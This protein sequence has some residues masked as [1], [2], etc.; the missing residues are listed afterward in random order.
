MKALS[1][2]AALL[3]AFGLALDS[4]SVRA[5]Q[6]SDEEVSQAYIYL[7]G[8]LLVTRQQQLDFQD[9]FKWNEIVHRKP[10]AVDWPNPNLDVAYSEA[11]VAVD[12]TSC[13]IVT[14]PEIKDRYYTVQF[15]NGWGETLANINE[16]LFPSRSSGDFAMCLRG[17]KVELP[18][19]TLRIDLPVKYSR[20]LARV[21]L[22]G[23]PDRAIALQHEFKFSTTGSPALP[24]IPKTPIFELGQLPGAEAFEA[25]AAAFN[26][27]PD[28]NAGL[29]GL[30]AQV[31]SIAA[32]IKD[33]AAERQR[34]DGIIK[35]HAFPE[36]AK[37]GAI[38]GH[39]VVHNGWA[40]PSVVGEYG[41][42]YL[43]RTLVN[44]G[45]IWANIKPEVLYYRGASDASGAELNGDHNYTLT[46]PKD[47][48]PS[49]FAKYFWS[50]IAV[51]S[52]NFRV[53]PNP[54]HRFLL[55]DQ[56][57]PQ[58][59]SDGSLTLYFAAEKPADA[60][61]GN[62]LPTPKGQKYRLTFR[63]YGP[64]D[65]VANGTYWPPALVKVN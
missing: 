60:P 21:A 57:H 61:D 35:S 2:T 15:L 48:L 43:T 7:L 19:D 63:F 18:G 20:V 53:L 33:N 11:W 14:V 4:T 32:A 47:A 39:G 51:D 28:L 5:Q 23:D 17:A 50:V 42:D 38:I 22:G 13:T 29:E 34:V 27:E 56:T 65:G 3:L 8:R 40:R 37:A 45:G 54:L 1:C 64:L 44:N 31:R 55:N 41:M 46:F 62:W 30:Q 36:L 59:G 52:T 9:G 49:R 16:R 6:V 12:E 58:Y 10:G 26:S 25:A 24:V